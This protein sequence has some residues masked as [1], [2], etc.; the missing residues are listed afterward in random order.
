MLKQLYV[1]IIHIK[2]M[3]MNFENKHIYI[4][5]VTTRSRKVYNGGTKLSCILDTE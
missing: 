2:A 3:L 1:P 5:T 4:Y